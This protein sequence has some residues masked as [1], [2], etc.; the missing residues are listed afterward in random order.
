MRNK[1]MIRKFWVA[2]AVLCMSQV[3]RAQV[4]EDRYINFTDIKGM[5]QSA[6][7]HAADGTDVG[8]GSGN[9]SIS[10]I[11]DNKTYW[12]ESSKNGDVYIDLS[13]VVELE[14]SEIMFSE[15]GYSFEQV[16]AIE[17]QI[18]D[19]RGG[20]ATAKKFSSLAHRDD[21]LTLAF[22]KGSVSTSA[23]RI[24]LH[25]DSNDKPI[26]IDEIEFVVSPTIRHKASKWYA[27]KDSF[28]LSSGVLGTFRDDQPMFEP[29]MS[30]AEPIQAAHTYID[31]I[32]MHKGSTTNLVLPTKKIIVRACRLISDGTAIAQTGPSRQT[33]K[34][35]V[36]QVSTTCLR[37]LIHPMMSIGLTMAM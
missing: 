20:W 27:I 16:S 32:Y 6:A 3:A 5:I 37:Q 34:T 8:S 17:V 22:S 7:A 26:A 14:F 4:S 28:G 2:L 9:N 11:Y 29:A 24:Y 13:F 10:A 21:R 33:T 31:T 19:G 12:W 25:T 15:S 18:P 1:T 23:L 30:S 36:A 35:T